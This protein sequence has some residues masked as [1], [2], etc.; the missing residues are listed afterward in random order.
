MLVCVSQAMHILTS[1][2][3]MQDNLHNASIIFL[4]ILFF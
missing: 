1:L 4:S 2:L 3:F